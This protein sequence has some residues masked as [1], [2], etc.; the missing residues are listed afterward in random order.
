LEYKQ[1]DEAK[2]I[3]GSIMQCRKEMNAHKEDLKL[4]TENINRIKQEIDRA[5][6][7]L[8]NKADKKRQTA[9]HK[10]MAPGFS[11]HTDGFEEEPER[12]DVI[13]EDELQMIRQMKDLKRDYRELFNS[14]KET[15]NAISYS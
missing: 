9:F 2:A 15:K 8:E 14:L 6:A 11:S 12:Q 4:K 1:T 10:S 7:W 5:K 13:D 3:E